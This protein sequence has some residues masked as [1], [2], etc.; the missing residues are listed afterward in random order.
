[1][2]FILQRSEVAWVY[3]KPMTDTSHSLHW[4]LQKPVQS[5]PPRE[6]GFLLWVQLIHSE[7]AWKTAQDPPTLPTSY[8]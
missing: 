8:R 3:M 1:M 4:L 2:F 5:W 6:Q 7:V